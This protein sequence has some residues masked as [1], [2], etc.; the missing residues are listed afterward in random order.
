MIT[1]IIAVLL[2][3]LCVGLICS[4]VYLRI[5]TKKNMA[6]IMNEKQD[7]KRTYAGD[8]LDKYEKF[9]DSTGEVIVDISS[10]GQDLQSSA[11]QI[12]QNIEGVSAAV[13]QMAAGIQETSASSEEISAS[14]SEMD[15]MIMTISSE[16]SVASSIS[17]EI[18]AR[19]AQL[20]QKSI[21]TKSNTEK[22]Y[23]DAKGSLFEALEK[24]SAVSMVYELTDSIMKI[25]SQTKLLSLN[26]NI[27]AAR[28]GEHGKGF[29]VV[30]E[31]INKL[32]NQ[33]SEIAAHIKKITE[34]IRSSVSE[35]SDSAKM[36][37]SFIEE[38]VLAEYGNLIHVGEQY[39]ADADNFNSAIG[40]IN[41]NVERLYA[42]GS[43]ISQAVG[44]LTKTTVDEAAGIEEI[45]ATIN[46]ILIQSNSVADC[47][48]VN[49][50][51]I[52]GLAEEIMK[53]DS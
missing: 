7:G 24:S 43:N 13:Q 29:A 15:D 33:S 12:R 16:T 28:A 38:N 2:A 35:L 37:L 27:E 50:K 40:R 5:K 17:N 51:N 18:R 26:A 8:Q 48:V 25:A 11:V 4:L 30:A 21:D 53:M 46:D 49:S 6:A 20:K 44:E 36:I 31:E 3:V 19:A 1:E 32:S 42:T 14:I 41:E 9:I 45:S 39:Y 10:A 34:D 52:E 22:I 47:A 23:D